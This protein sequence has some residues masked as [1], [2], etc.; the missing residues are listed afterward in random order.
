LDNPSTSP[1]SQAQT[2][3]KRAL[4]V[5][6]RKHFSPFKAYI[7]RDHNLVVCLNPKV[8]STAF[9]SIL[10]EGLKRHNLPPLRGRA[11]RRYMTAPL[12]DYFH[13]FGQPEAYEFHCFVR[14][15]YARVIS[16]WN[17]KMVRGHREGY[18]RSMKG[19][20]PTIKAFA[21]EAGLPGSE[22]DEVV[23]FPTFLSFVE[24][25]PEGQRNQHWDSQVLVLAADLIPFKGIYDI[26]EDFAGGMCDV[27]SRVGIDREWVAQKV[28]RP[29][30]ASGRI[31]EPVLDEALAQRVYDLYRR[32]F[33]H[34]GFDPESWQGK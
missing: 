17:D 3:F 22:P 18:S 30:N 12:R 15:P 23:P 21:G 27:L 31:T 2:P 26:G 8:G 32:D 7:R 29:Q 5:F 28:A 34:F 19:L 14:N 33:D 11:W 24:S 4:S 25:K 16:A 6:R 10:V 9:R 20:V 13:A 1:D